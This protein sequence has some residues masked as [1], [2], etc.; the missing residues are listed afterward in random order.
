MKSSK[1]SDFRYYFFK[2]R[3]EELKGTEVPEVLGGCLQS[4][5]VQGNP[6]VLIFDNLK[7]HKCTNVKS[8]REKEEKRSNIDHLKARNAIRKLHVDSCG[9]KLSKCR[10]VGTGGPE[11]NVTPPVFCLVS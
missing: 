10:A 6:D 4:L 11:G 2:T 7:L 8:R 5:E 1:K 3:L 9:C